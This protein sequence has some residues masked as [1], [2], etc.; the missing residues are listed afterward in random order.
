MEMRPLEAF[1]RLADMANISGATAGDALVIA[2]EVVAA[3]DRHGSYPQAMG[4][5]RKFYERGDLRSV[6][7]EPLDKLM[8]WPAVVEIAEAASRM[9]RTFKV[10]GWRNE[11]LK[12]AG[13]GDNAGVSALFE[14][15]PHA[16]VD[17]YGFWRGQL[18]HLEAMSEAER[19][20]DPEYDEKVAWMRRVVAELE[21]FLRM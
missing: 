19:R 6:R 13:H 20:D 15:A 14:L 10:D 5:L 18:E 11:I 12:S 1:H 16:T 7:D 3:V 2:V 9:A 8:S 4:D 21:P 17:A